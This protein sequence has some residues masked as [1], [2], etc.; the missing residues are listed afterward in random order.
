M[1]GKIIVVIL[2]LAIVFNL[3]RGLFFLV[4]DQER[5]NKRVVNSLSWRIGLSIGLFILLLLLNH[6][7][8]VEFHSMPQVKPE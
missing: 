2:L 4:K 6:F 3:F 8:I 7:G 1:L 5:G